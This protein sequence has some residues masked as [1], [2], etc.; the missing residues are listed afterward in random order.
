MHLSRPFCLVNFYRKIQRENHN[1]TLMP[2]LWLGPFVHTWIGLD[3]N[4]SLSSPIV[5]MSGNEGPVVLH[6]SLHKSIYIAYIYAWLVSCCR[7]HESVKESLKK[8]V[9]LRPGAKRL[10]AAVSVLLMFGSAW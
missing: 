4:Y 7:Q 2:T 10:A 5:P 8:V 9:I 1:R 3:G 6:N